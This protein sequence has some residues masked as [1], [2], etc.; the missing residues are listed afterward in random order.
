MLACACGKSPAR[1]R[2]A[3]VSN[4]TDG[5]VSVIDLAAQR[6]ISTIHVG[7]RPRGVHARRCARVRHERK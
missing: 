4:E 7:K 3:Y 6:V 5:T 1:P 2:R